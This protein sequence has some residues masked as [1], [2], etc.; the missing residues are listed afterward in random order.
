MNDILEDGV[1]PDQRA[2]PQPLHYNLEIAVDDGKNFPEGRLV[3]VPSMNADVGGVGGPM[4]T[5]TFHDQVFKSR[6]MQTTVDTC[7][8]EEETTFFVHALD[9]A[10]ALYAAQRG[11]ESGP[12]ISLECTSVH[13]LTHQLIGSCNILL[14]DIM[15]EALSSEG[16]AKTF[17]LRDAKDR[18][19]AGPRGEA[20]TISLRFK[21]TSIHSGEQWSKPTLADTINSSESKV[22]LRPVLLGGTNSAPR[23]MPK[24]ASKDDAPDSSVHGD[25]SVYVS[26]FQMMD[27]DDDGSFYWRER[28][29]SVMES[30]AVNVFVV[31]LILVDVGNVMYFLVNAYDTQTDEEPWEQVIE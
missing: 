25:G 6:G 10:H 11:S 28:L 22:D 18:P 15:D 21:A 29:N 7:H 30:L 31:L 23:T 19:V 14:K 20:S 3:G 24:N 17:E 13:L 2:R 4:V 26:E 27:S 16:T 12:Y 5:L 9:I 8:W 1:P